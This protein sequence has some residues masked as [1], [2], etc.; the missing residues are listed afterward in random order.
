MLEYSAENSYF[1]KNIIFNMFKSR[2]KN[3]VITQDSIKLF[4][5]LINIMAVSNNEPIIPFFTEN[6]ISFNI[7]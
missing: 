4:F 7:L 2:V 1:T 5:E 3:Q 6:L